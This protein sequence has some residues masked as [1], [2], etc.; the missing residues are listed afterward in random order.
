MTGS[1]TTS[2]IVAFDGQIYGLDISLRE[3]PA[4][5]TIRADS[6]AAVSIDGR[7]EGTTP[8]PEADRGRVGDPP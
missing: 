3:K 1:S 4:L 6:G 5:L 7:N 8:L 2:E